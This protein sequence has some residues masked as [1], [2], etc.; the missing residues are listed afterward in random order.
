MGAMLST[1]T[2]ALPTS[3]HSHRALTCP[4]L[5]LSVWKVTRSKLSDSPQ[6][7]LNRA[8]YHITSA[9]IVLAGLSSTVFVRKCLS[10]VQQPDATAS[11]LKLTA[12]LW[13]LNQLPSMTTHGDVRKELSSTRRGMLR[14][15]S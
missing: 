3:K 13:D 8:S 4:K 14:S 11:G 9:V 6:H 7:A 12:P 10:V 2:R 1:S 15:K 5:A